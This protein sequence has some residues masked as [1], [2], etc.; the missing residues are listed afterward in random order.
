MSWDHILICLSGVT[1]QHMTT[2]PTFSCSVDA[3]R[4]V[5]S[6]KQ[7]EVERGCLQYVQ[8]VL[9]SVCSMYIVH[10]S[11]LPRYRQLMLPYI[12]NLS[13]CCPF[14]NLGAFP[15]REISQITLLCKVIHRWQLVSCSMTRSFFF[16]K[17]L[18]CE[19]SLICCCKENIK[20]TNL[21]YTV[22]SISIVQSM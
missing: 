10:H 1:S 14:I 18:A 20:D 9:E 6:W 4:Y 13:C 15:G 8:K 12:L 2:S 21:V 11:S 5:L 22:T 7:C 17:G 16:V 3:K 19:T